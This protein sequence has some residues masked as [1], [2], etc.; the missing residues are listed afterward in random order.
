[1]STEKNGVKLSA[2]YRAQAIGFVALAASLAVSLT[3]EPGQREGLNL[4]LTVIGSI[5]TI[6]GLRRSE[7][8]NK[9]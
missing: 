7:K 1:M 6:V 5:Y 2:V 3:S 4:L 8:F 9:Q